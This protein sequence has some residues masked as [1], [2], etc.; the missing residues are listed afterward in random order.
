MIHR[1]PEQ[2]SYMLHE[3]AQQYQGSGTGFLSIKSF[4]HGPALYTV[5]RNRY[6]LN[7]T[8]YLL[9]NHGQPYSITIESDHPVE[10]LCLFFA[11]GFAETVR[12]SLTAPTDQL[13]LELEPPSTSVLRFFQ[14]TYPHDQL[15]S[16]VLFHLRTVLTHYAPEQGWLTECLHVIMERLLQVHANVYT[17]VAAVPAA[18]AATREEVY[19]RLYYAR[20]YADALFA[21]PITLADMAQV[22]S[23]S[24]NH[25]LRMFKHVF[26]QTPYQYVTAKRLEHARTLLIHTNQSVTDICFAVV[27]ESLVSF[28]WLF[29]RRIGV[30]PTVY[31]RQ[32]R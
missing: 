15:L 31:R 12:R 23:L 14:R 11:P 20:D 28:S 26:H 8:A 27:F 6:A 24:P 32:K 4:F 5:G 16:P 30:S 29:R 22:A 1:L 21:T 25:L 10:S 3:Q 17:E 9:L 7:D 13:L 18:R 2:S 19:R